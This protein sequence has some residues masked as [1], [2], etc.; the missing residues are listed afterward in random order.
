MLLVELCTGSCPFK[1][2][3]ELS[4]L[5]EI[6]KIVGTPPS[7]YLK[8]YCGI[9]PDLTVASYNSKLT[10]Y[11]LCNNN[12]VLEDESSDFGYFIDLVGKCLEFDP[13]K[14]ITVDKALEHEFLK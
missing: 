13:S 3:S 5:F 7:Q 2:D 11:L 6:F 12:M 4:Q 14:R 1:G 10:E 8:S 9:F